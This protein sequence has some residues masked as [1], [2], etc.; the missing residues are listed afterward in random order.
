MH[1]V[2]AEVIK[3]AA[4]GDTSGLKVKGDEESTQISVVTTDKLVAAIATLHAPLVE[5]AGISGLP[6]QDVLAKLLAYGPYSDNEIVVNRMVR[7]VTLQDDTRSEMEVPVSFTFKDR[8]GGRATYHLS[9][10]KSIAGAAPPTTRLDFEITPDKERL[11]E[12]NKLTSIFSSPDC[13]VMTP[14]VEDGNLFF[15]IGDEGATTNSARMLF[16][17]G[18]SFHDGRL[19]EL[20]V[21]VFLQILKV[22]GD[23]ETTIGFGKSVICVKFSGEHASYE[24]WQRFGKV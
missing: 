7:T 2:L 20:M 3:L 22:A 12:L 16:Q 18:V 15:D 19:K 9:H 8:K 14:F 21:P 5:L 4:V 13:K 10:Q 11:K 23:R 1:N 6:H 24:I 17:E